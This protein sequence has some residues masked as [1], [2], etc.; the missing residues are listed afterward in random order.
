[1]F[2]FKWL[3]I[4]VFLKVCARERLNNGIHRASLLSCFHIFESEAK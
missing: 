1:M 2:F 4:L 3:S